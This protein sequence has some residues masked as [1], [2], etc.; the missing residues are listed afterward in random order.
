MTTTSPEE[1]KA[2]ILEAFDT[3]FNKRD[4]VAA[5]RFWSDHLSRHTI[6]SNLR[7]IFRTLDIG[8]R[9]ELTRLVEEHAYAG[10]AAS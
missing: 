5:E 8:S 10:D 1:N 7:H 2:L 6:N 3:L 9:V 4:H